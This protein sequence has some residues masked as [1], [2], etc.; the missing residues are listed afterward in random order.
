VWRQLF[1]A[2]HEIS[3]GASAS[4]LPPFGE[5]HAQVPTPSKPAH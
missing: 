1:A 5:C 2:A 3:Q 4:E